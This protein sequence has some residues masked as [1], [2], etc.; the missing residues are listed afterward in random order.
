[1][2]ATIKVYVLC[3]VDFIFI[4][5]FVDHID[6]F[7]YLS[8]FQPLIWLFLRNIKYRFLYEFTQMFNVLHCLN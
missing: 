4:Q 8:I 7:S 1:M 2:D 3:V 6:N 5:H